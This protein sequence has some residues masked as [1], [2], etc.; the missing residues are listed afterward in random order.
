[1]DKYDYEFIRAVLV[2]AYESAPMGFNNATMTYGEFKVEWTTIIVN[3]MPMMEVKI[4]GDDMLY[5]RVSDLENAIGIFGR[6]WK[7]YD[8]G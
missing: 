8:N 3:D 6:W 4:W 2:A 7:D 5:W 1:M